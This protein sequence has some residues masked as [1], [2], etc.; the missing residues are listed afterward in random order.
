[1]GRRC[2]VRR[3]QSAAV[4]G[5][6]LLA[7]LFLAACGG[8]GGDGGDTLPCTTLVF[9]RALANLADGD[10]YLDQAS[11]TCS[12]VG[13][14]VLVNNLDSIWSASFDLSFPSSLLTYDSYTLGPLLQKGSPSTPPFVQVAQVGGTVQ[15]VMSRFAPDPPV[16]AVGSE[17]LITIRFRRIAA[18]SGAIDFDTS[19]TSLVGEVLL[20]DAIPVGSQLAATFAPGHGGLVTVP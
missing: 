4:R 19:G 20:D 13:V 11:G 18:G 6:L 7:T 3:P 9:D 1:M 17:A 16:N 12:T 10:V 2:F 5:F 14:T 8:G 15:V